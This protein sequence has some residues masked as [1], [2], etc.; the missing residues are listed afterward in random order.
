MK[1]KVYCQMYSILRTS[2]DGLLDALKSLSEMG[3]DGIEGMGDNT[4]GLSVEEFKKYVKDL[5]LDCISFHSLKD[6][7]MLAFGQEMGA[8]FT[9]IRP[10]ENLKTV[11][12]VKHAAEK[13]TAQAKLISKYGMK[14]VVHNHATEFRHPVDAED[15]SFYELLLQN[16]DPEYVAFELDLG[17]AQLAGVN[18]GNLI[19]KYPGR[20]PLLHV[21]ECNRIAKTSEELDH[22]PRSI[23]EMNKVQTASGDNKNFIKGAPAFTQEQM[24]LLYESRNWNVE[25]GHGLIDWKDVRDAAEAQGVQAY[26]NEREYYTINGKKL[27]PIEYAKLDCE[28]LK[29]L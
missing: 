29:S 28:F 14:A 5:N 20:F 13:L 25:L 8:R 17:W 21:K 6:E 11:D 4:E 18:C 7:S 19:R 23:M 22:F 9:D 24:D 1:N 15:T 26:I 12:D 16:T 10:D 2:R 3:Y 27:S